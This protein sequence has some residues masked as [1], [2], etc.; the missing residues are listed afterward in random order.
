MASTFKN[1][2]VDVLAT[3]TTVYTAPAGV[4]AVIFGFNLANVD[5][6]NDA[7]VIVEVYDDSAAVHKTIG[8]GVLVPAE[9]TLVWDGKIVL[10]E[11]DILKVT[12]SAAGDV[13]A[14]ASIVEKN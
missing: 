13:V 14:Y 5:G 6:V 8:Q 3:Q 12:A 1:A 10:E 11:N 4:Q 7:T 2:S 9:N